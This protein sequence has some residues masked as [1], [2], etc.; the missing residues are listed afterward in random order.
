[1]AAPPHSAGPLLLGIQD[2]GAHNRLDFY[3]DRMFAVLARP[4]ADSQMQMPI[5]T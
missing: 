5:S 3:N 4:P 1:M 2:F